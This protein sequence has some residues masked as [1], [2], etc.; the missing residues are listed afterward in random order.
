MQYSAY[1]EP[2]SLIFFNFKFFF[3]FSLLS[4]LSNSNLHRICTLRECWIRLHIYKSS[5]IRMQFD[6]ENNVNFLIDEHIR[7]VQPSF[8]AIQLRILFWNHY[9]HSASN[10]VRL[11]FFFGFLYSPV[12]ISV[13]RALFFLKFVS[14]N[15]SFICT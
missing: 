1:N 15:L 14:L 3:L 12:S 2:F 13:L 11:L 8:G 4:L 10:S 9:D 6:N 5:R 7:L